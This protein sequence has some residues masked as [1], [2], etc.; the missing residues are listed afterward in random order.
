[1]LSTNPC[2][3]EASP[4]ATKLLEE[5]AEKR[6]G[7]REE[8]QRGTTLSC[9]RRLSLLLLF[10]TFHELLLPISIHQ[11]PLF[12]AMDFCPASTC[13][14]LHVCTPYPRLQD[15]ISRV[16]VT[17]LSIHKVQLPS[18]RRFAGARARAPVRKWPFFPIATP[19]YRQGLLPWP[20]QS[21]P[22]DT[23]DPLITR[24]TGRIDENLVEALLLMP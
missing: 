24:L 19:R 18:R 21:P 5:E 12:P 7:H 9:T 15:R 16:R 14:C 8:R 4:V 23:W 11:Q 22:H 20:S 6:T 3:Q 1:M 10:G 17:P 13:I 2:L